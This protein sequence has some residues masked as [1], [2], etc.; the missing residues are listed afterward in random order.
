MIAP[1]LAHG[2]SMPEDMYYTVDTHAIVRNFPETKRDVPAENVAQSAL[3][4]V[5][6]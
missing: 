4:L 5:C 1:S 2:Q 3:R 6:V